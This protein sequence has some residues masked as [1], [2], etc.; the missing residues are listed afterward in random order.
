MK[1]WDIF[2]FSLLVIAHT[3]PIPAHQKAVVLVPVADLVGDPLG[4][5]GPAAGLYHQLPVCGG[6]QHVKSCKRIHQLLFNEIVDII[7]REGGLV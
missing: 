1:K 3:A 4:S 7:K 6:K 2:V 5:L